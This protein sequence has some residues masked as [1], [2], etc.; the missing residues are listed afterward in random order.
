LFMNLR[1]WPSGEIR[2]YFDSDLRFIRAAFP[3]SARILKT[4]HAKGRESTHYLIKN[5]GG[6][7][8]LPQASLLALRTRFGALSAHIPP[9]NRLVQ[10]GL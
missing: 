7:H 10:C 4:N 5:Q 8:S 3:E 2:A 1:L 9:R 6:H